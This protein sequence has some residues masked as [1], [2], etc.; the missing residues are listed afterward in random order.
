VPDSAMKTA[1]SRG[2]GIPAGETESPALLRES[3]G[4]IAVLTLNRPHARN[5]LSG[6]ML[7]ALQR[8]LADIAASKGTRAVVIAAEG[9]VFSAGHDLKE[10]SAHRS[11]ADG[12][13]GYVR[14]LMVSCSAVM[15]AMLRLPQPV[16]AAV[17]GTATA[18]GCQL[19]ATC[20]LAVASTAAKFC[21]PGVQIGLFCSTPMV[22]LT[23]NVT[24][25]HAMEMLL[26]GDTISAE[27]A[28]RIGLVNR[29]V[30]RGTAREQALAL[31]RGIA[32][33]SKA[34]V[35]LGKQA[36]YRQI[37]MGVADA[38]A[39]ASEVMVENMMLHDAA[40]GISAFVEKR[41]P[42]WDDR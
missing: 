1:S 17:E 34:V 15:L 6:E 22:A 41:P 36:F 33:R 14:Q 20:D 35:K 12:G 7:G 31:A 37:E 18:A 11:D 2:S 42:H 16:I 10:V 30:E 29:V 24:R 40:E 27:D 9:S 23:R 8:A 39:Y 21:T 19:V 32:A 13:Q 26:T 25:K 3:I 38:Y 5:A 28:W 4:S